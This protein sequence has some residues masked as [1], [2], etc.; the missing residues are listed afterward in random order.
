MQVTSR[1]FPKKLFPYMLLCETCSMSTVKCQLPLILWNMVSQF[2]T[3]HLL[4][5]SYYQ[6]YV[7]LCF[8]FTSLI[9]YFI[10]AFKYFFF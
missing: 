5:L 2:L 1:G 7:F 4:S 9:L 6:L 10:F 8:L 3:L